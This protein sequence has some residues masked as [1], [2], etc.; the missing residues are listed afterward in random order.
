M[1]ATATVKATANRAKAAARKARREAG[2]LP[3]IKRGPSP[4]GYAVVEYD[5]F[6]DHFE[7][8]GMTQAQLAEKAGVT[9][10][11]VSLLVAGTRARCKPET[12]LRIVAALDVD[13]FMAFQVATTHNQ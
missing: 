5:R 11:A 3:K 10:Q 12:A 6:M 7:K 4:T 13:L 2:E 8:S 9:Q 1:A